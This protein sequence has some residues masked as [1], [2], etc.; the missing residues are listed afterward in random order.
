MARVARISS[1]LI[2]AAAHRLIP[3]SRP[4]RPDLLSALRAQE[5]AYM[6]APVEETFR[7]AD[8]IA[9]WTSTLEAG[10]DESLGKGVL[11]RKRCQP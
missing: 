5:N 3:A 8:G 4:M 2:A 1:S 7:Y 10:R 11:S 9:E 6:G